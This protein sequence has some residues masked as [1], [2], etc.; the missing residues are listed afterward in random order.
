MS[1]IKNQKHMNTPEIRQGWLRQ[2]IFFTVL[3]VVTMLLA[4]LI[5]RLYTRH[6]QKIEMLD[7]TGKNLT[8]AEELVQKNRF[9]LIVN[10][11]V[12]VVGK[13]RGIILDQN[14]KPGSFVKK[15]RKIYITITKGDA[16]KI[17]VENLPSLYGNA[18]DQKKKELKYREINAEIKSYSYDAGEPNHILEVWYNGQKII[19]QSEK[20]N[21]VEINKGDTLYFVLSEREGGET[22]VP[23]LRCL[24][25]EEAHFI[26]ESNKLVMGEI[27][28]KS[29]VKPGEDM[30][31]ISQDPPYDGM[32]NI[33]RGS[34]VSVVLSSQKPVDCPE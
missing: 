28:K 1:A 33:E 19:D 14:P 29:D 17:L 20:R 11:S 6:G 16:D 13:P 18:Y 12:F 27:E 5:L 26:L 15:H 34:S 21:D 2:F 4:M 7:L 22:P 25:L 24:T 9:E 23:D 8:E 10:D 31:V 3:A 30:F 32:S